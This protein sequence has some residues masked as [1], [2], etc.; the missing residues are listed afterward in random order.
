MALT[1]QQQEITLNGG[2]D[3][4]QSVE[5]QDVSTLRRVENL[6]WN[7]LKQLEKR[8]TYA[9]TATPST[10]GGYTD[11]DIQA[12]FS[13][14][15]EVFGITAGNGL[16]VVNPGTPTEANYVV[17]DPAPDG[18]LGFY[19]KYM[20]QACKVSRRMVERSQNNSLGEGIYGCA[21][22]IYGE[23]TLVI[24]WLEVTATRHT[25][26]AKAID[27]DTETVLS[28]TAIYSNVNATLPDFEM[29]A[30]PYYES[31]KEGVL[32]C[33]TSGT[34]APYTVQCFRYDVASKLFVQEAN[35]TNNAKYVKIALANDA[36][37]T[38]KVYFA[39]TDNTTGFV[40]AQYRTIST[41]TTTH[42]STVAGQHGVCFCLNSVATLLVSCVGATAVKAECFGTPASVATLLTPSNETFY[43][44]TAAL[45]GDH[46]IVYT[47]A[48]PLALGIR[49]RTCNA[50]VTATTVT[51]GN[52]TLIPNA[53]LASSAFTF[54]SRAYCIVALD[55]SFSISTPRLT[56]LVVAR[57]ADGNNA[58]AT[59]ARHDPIARFCHQVYYSPIEAGV[60]LQSGAAII[61]NRLHVVSPCN[62]T[63]DAS[64]TYQARL[65][66]NLMHCV[67]DLANGPMPL[68]SLEIDGTTI[69]ASGLPF[70]WDGDTPSEHAPICK[71][72]IAGVDSSSGTGTTFATACSVR[73]IWRWIDA[74]GR[75]H[76][77]APS[78]LFSTGTLSNKSLSVYVTKPP[79]T[80]YDGVTANLLEPELYITTQGNTVYYLANNSGGRKLIPSS[81]ESRGTY[82]IYTVVLEGVNGN[83]QIYS[84][85]TTSPEIA[86]EAPPSF[87]SIV[88]IVDRLW[89]LDAE[90]LTR[91]WYTKPLVAGYA[92]EWNALCTLYI[93]DDCVAISENN[94][95]PTILARRGI[96]QVYGEGP[97]AT[98]SNGTFA[99]ARRLPH[100]VT[101]VDSLVCR[102]KLGLVFRGRRG[103]YLLGVDLGLRDLGLPIDPSSQAFS[104]GRSNSASKY[105]Y[106]KVLYD[107]PH[108][109][110]RILDAFHS[111]HWVYNVVEDKW[112]QWT[113][114]T[115]AQ[116]HADMCIADGRV[117]Y[118]HV[119]AASATSIRREYGVD[120]ASYNFS[121]EGW[122]LQTPWIRFG[123]VAGYGRLWNML[124]AISMDFARSG[125]ASIVVTLD[126][127]SPDYDS[128]VDTFTFVTFP[129]QTLPLRSVLRCPPSHQRAMTF[130][131]TI[132]ETCSAPYLG[133]VPIALRFVMGVDPKALKRLPPRAVEGSST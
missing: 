30:V 24:A 38:S 27:I 106:A 5:L 51:A 8:P 6:R 23:T 76:R 14:E 131:V 40:K 53:W 94:G 52:V 44:V 118:L 80:A 79:F 105:S 120:E 88:R 92:P 57:Y 39:Y 104:L 22:A 32:I 9:S 85:G 41:V 10:P 20:P 33:C 129:L 89:A 71:P 130:Q 59:Y 114:S 113:L 58:L 34:A 127:V 54:R 84:V 110:I 91:V 103:F 77:S 46:V 18:N 31:A 17:P 107:E 95:V 121:A 108:N 86:A 64:P 4:K 49:V 2:L 116:N 111:I 133:T 16:V 78:D 112:S 60:F 1:E 75:L 83:P 7:A 56:S 117:W 28:A 122:L 67:V 35:F 21:H 128:G 43:G 82:W 70:E 124:L 37:L 50:A 101:C 61:S 42:N 13:R 119:G 123:G 126:A 63:E 96:W 19:R 100:E 72:R 25:L 93:G 48:F 115:S 45:Q 3:V 11:K 55:P 12:V 97:D 69:V 109:E 98:L 102:T 81:V 26:K 125:L 15:N 87:R 65:A 74:K 90:D 66:T 73:A 132:Q 29:V 62:L 99:P 47:N 36:G 68:P